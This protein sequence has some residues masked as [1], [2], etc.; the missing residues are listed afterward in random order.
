MKKME[1]FLAVLILIL[2]TVLVLKLNE[3]GQLK[4]AIV[5]SEK[6][7]QYLIEGYKPELLVLPLQEEVRFPNSLSVFVL[8][9][10]RR[11]EDPI[12]GTAAGYS[13]KL[14]VN[15]MV[16]PIRGSNIFTYATDSLGIVE[17]SSRYYR[18]EYEGSITGLEGKVKK[19]TKTMYLSQKGR[20]IS[21]SPQ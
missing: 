18:L 8:P 12:V 9:F 11:V 16:G 1:M 2:G 14:H 10:L 13:P 7:Y 3:I 19:L 17:D 15:S 4:E 5:K 21:I 6:E 20:K